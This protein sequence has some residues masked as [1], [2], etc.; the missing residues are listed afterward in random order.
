M[1][2]EEPMERFVS[3]LD[4]AL[5]ASSWERHFGREVGFNPISN[6]VPRWS[7]GQCEPMPVTV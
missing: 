2:A 6:F 1:E 7:A 4:E 5:G 3:E